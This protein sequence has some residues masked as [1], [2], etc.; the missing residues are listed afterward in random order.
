MSR[1]KS[2]AAAT[3]IAG[4][5]VLSLPLIA[6][7]GTI[8]S[9]DGRHGDGRGSVGYAARIHFEKHVVDPVAFV[10]E[11]TTSGAAHGTL[12]SNLLTQLGSS[13][14]Y[15]IVSFRWTVNARKHSFVAQTTGTI[16]N[17]T[18]EVS[19][20]GSIVSG[21]NAGAKVL[22]LGQGDGAGNFEGDLI[23]LLPHD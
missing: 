2:I 1:R 11:G 16:N 17:A 13:G 8:A 18:G 15:S 21:W 19:M 3:G 5:L 6:H 22:E 10:F 7:A 23:V 4:V 20:A 14:D 12:R 9:A